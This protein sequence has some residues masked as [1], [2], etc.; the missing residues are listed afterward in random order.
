M[1]VY[2]LINEL[3]KHNPHATVV[4]PDTSGSADFEI[5]GDVKFRCGTD[6]NGY[7]VY[8]REAKNDGSA[9]NL[10]LVALS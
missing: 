1:Q 6:T 3:E 4:F 9:E 2:E 10:D 5:V 8:F 7:G